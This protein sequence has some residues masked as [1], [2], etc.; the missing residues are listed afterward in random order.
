M[1]CTFACG[2]RGNR[3]YF[4]TR[5]AMESSGVSACL[6]VLTQTMICS[7][8]PEIL[9]IVVDHLHDQP[10]TLGACCVVS[11]SWIPRS[12]IHIFARVKLNAY[13]PST[14]RHWIAAFPDPL[15][16]PAHYARTL[17]V[18]GLRLVTRT[19]ENVTPW[20]RAFHNVVQLHV[21]LQGWGGLDDRASLVPFHGLSPAIRLLRLKSSVTQPSVNFELLCSFSLLEE[22]EFLRSPLST[23]L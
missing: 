20:I 10:T 21:E 22:L 3:A 17:T 8:P 15:N 9:D 11:R 14:V 12:R 7:L 23:R 6:G 2:D 4:R 13:G 16:S 5:P 19:G 18:I 1:C